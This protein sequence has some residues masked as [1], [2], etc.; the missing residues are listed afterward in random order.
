MT[1]RDLRDLLDAAADDGGRTSLSGITLI[2]KARRTR[3]RRRTI[4]SGAVT[5]AV[6]VAGLALAGSG[7][8]PVEHKQLTAQSDRQ[9]L[10]LNIEANNSGG[11]SRPYDDFAHML[12]DLESASVDSVV[13]GRVVK[14]DA[15][16]GFL[17]GDGGPSA[18]GAS[19]TLTAFDDPDASWRTMTVTVSVATYLSGDGPSDLILD[20]PLRG[21]T[22]DG[23][24]WTAVARGLKGLGQILL[25]SD[26]LPESPG[27]T[28]L[29][30]LA[31]DLPYSIATVDDTG[32]IDFVFADGSNGPTSNDFVG[33]LDTVGE[34][35]EALTA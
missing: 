18:G 22:A 27:Y 8:S 33:V 21:D 35:H 7:T 23:E 16:V 12:T 10:R 20:W 14:V 5:T 26:G 13:V 28:G 3:R 9:A 4:W 24:D 34:V 31:V 25:L 30:R 32:K 17:E 19:K 29:S 6:V 15:G 1:E 11:F 2:A